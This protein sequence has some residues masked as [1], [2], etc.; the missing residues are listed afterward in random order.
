MNRINSEADRINIIG[1]SGSPDKNSST[2]LAL[3]KVLQGAVEAGACV[4]LIDLGEMNLPIISPAEE[5]FYPED[6]FTLRS[7][8]KNADGIVLATP[9]YYGSMSGLL[10]NAIDLSV[11]GD[12][13]DKPVA[14]VGVAGG[15]AGAINSLNAMRTMCRNLHAW[16]L[17]QEVS[18]ASA[19]KVFEKNGNIL[20]DKIGS[21]L[22]DLGSSLSEIT[23]L[24]KLYRIG[25]I[26]SQLGE[27]LNN[28]EKLEAS[29]SRLLKKVI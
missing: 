1:I 29:G 18:V 9:E 8:I 11:Y 19:H 4:E 6:V 7:A 22:F 28:K 24:F 10:K 3:K 17:P 23:A 2:T 15:E 27:L 21:R 20:D 16:A 5:D 12:F 26:Y 14:L 13:K 25:K